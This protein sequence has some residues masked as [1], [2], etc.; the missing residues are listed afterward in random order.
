MINKI[1]LNLIKLT[2]FLLQLQ[3][4][5]T[6]ANDKL[7][8]FYWGFI[9]AYSLELVFDTTAITIGVPLILALSKELR[10]GV[11]DDKGISLGTVELLDIAFTVLP[12]ILISLL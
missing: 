5:I 3:S 9:Y 10:D 7:G 1:K 2:K 6:P 11:A 8:H 12:G 4:R